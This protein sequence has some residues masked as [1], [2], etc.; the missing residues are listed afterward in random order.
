MGISMAR[1]TQKGRY[2]LRN[3]SKYEGNVLNVIF[4]SSWEKRFMIFLDNHDS[5]ISW[6]SE[7]V[8]VP[9]FW[10]MDQ[11]MHRYYPD[12]VVTM[13]T[14]SGVIRMMVEVKPYGQTIEPKKTK[15]KRDST[16]LLEVETYTKNIAKWKA[17]ERYCANEGWIFRIITEKELFKGKTW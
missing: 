17:A 14:N 12:F 8:V 5:I 11:K 7:E 10:E 4:R 3:P 13:K 1:E 2:V 15:N 16:F 9:Y 6:S